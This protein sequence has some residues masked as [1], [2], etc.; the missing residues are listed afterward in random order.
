MFTQQRAPDA[1]GE[2]EPALAALEA[3]ARVRVVGADR[4]A[5]GADLGDHD[6][7]RRRRGRVGVDASSAS[8]SSSSGQ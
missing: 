4:V 3:A 5:P 1:V 6:V 8:A 2:R 7:G